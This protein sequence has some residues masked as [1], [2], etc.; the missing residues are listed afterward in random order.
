MMRDS[1]CVEPNACGVLQRSIPSTLT[2]RRAS[3]R[4]AALPIA[5]K[6]TTI[7]SNIRHLERLRA[8]TRLIEQLPSQ[9]AHLSL[10][11]AK[12]HTDFGLRC[13][14]FHIAG[15][16]RGNDVKF[17]VAV[18]AKLSGIK[19]KPAACDQSPRK[20]RERPGCAFA[21]KYCHASY[22]A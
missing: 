10:G 16:V 13:F 18:P 11:I 12:S 4:S 3:S 7:T 8:Q 9:H 15:I 19:C 6:P 21:V 14:D 2:P 20:L 1:P 22:S 17:I 5:P